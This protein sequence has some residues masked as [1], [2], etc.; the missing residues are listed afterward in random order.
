MKHQASRELYAYWNAL[1]G[2]RAAPERRDIDP[3]AIRAVLADTVMIEVERSGSGRAKFPIRLSGTRVN[4]LLG[5]DLK[6]RSLT[7]LWRLQDRRE[8]AAL[9]TMVMDDT[10]PIVAG[11]IA[12]PP[13]ADP[14]N[15]ELL[16]LPL[17]YGGRTHARLLGALSC[18]NAPSWLGLAP[19]APLTL[20]SH[21]MI[22]AGP[23][24]LGAD[25]LLAAEIASGG[26]RYGQF[27]I[28]EG[29]RA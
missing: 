4:A 7:S 20:A 17:R 21:R 23:S 2:G 15:L 26:T 14:V 11:A 3:A 6:G 8:I 22:D 28:Y 9:A 29:G 18:C 16:L 12:G 27:V 5:S 19:V 24:A 10:Q 25:M 1:R 13:G